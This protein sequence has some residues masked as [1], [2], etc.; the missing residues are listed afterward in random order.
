MKFSKIKLCRFLLFRGL[1]ELHSKK[2]LRKVNFT[3][4]TVATLCCRQCKWLLRT[5][6]KKK[7]PEN[8]FKG[9][10]VDPI[11]FS[12]GRTHTCILLTGAIK[13]TKIPFGVAE[14]F[15]A[16]NQKPLHDIYHTVQ[17]AKKVN[18]TEKM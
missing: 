18:Y 10:V 8:L 16:D 3:Y 13:L 15:R 6:L 11:S 17:T 5:G 4:Y 7:I 2:Y 14:F 9:G 1:R 12:S